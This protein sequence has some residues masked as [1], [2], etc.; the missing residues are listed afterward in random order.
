MS[1]PPK[2]ARKIIKEL[3]RFSVDAVNDH[4]CTYEL[5]IPRD[6]FLNSAAAPHRKQCLAMLTARALQG[7]ASIKAHERGRQTIS[8]KCRRDSA[9][10]GGNALKLSE[11]GGVDEG[12]QTVAR[13]E[14]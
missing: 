2:G 10:T 13:S 14:A 3:L 4:L 11:P 1:P 5:R 7:A 6:E 9:E 12:R 8:P